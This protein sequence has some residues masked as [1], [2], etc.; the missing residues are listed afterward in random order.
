MNHL[1]LEGER[2]I[3][4]DNLRA[5]VGQLRA[6]RSSEEGP[7]GDGKVGAIRESFK[8]EEV[9]ETLW[10]EGGGGISHVKR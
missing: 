4:K 10:A 8:E 3:P 1:F 7:D 5:V 2:V 9:Q 6:P